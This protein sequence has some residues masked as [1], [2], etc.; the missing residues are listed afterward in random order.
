MGEKKICVYA[1]CKN[2]EKFVERWMNSMREADAV[3]VLDTGSDDRSVDRLRALGAVV[4]I[5]KIVPWRFDAA[6][7]ASL[8]MVPEDC[9]ICV[10]TDLDEVFRPGWR[11]ALEQSWTP[12][13]VR[14]RYRYTWNFRPDGSE[15]IVF[16]ADKIHARR[17]FSWV[18]PVHEVLRSE[19]ETGTTVTAVGVQLDHRADRTK[20]RSQYLPLLELSVREDPTDD[21]NMHYLG[22]EYMF[23]GRYREAVDT[24]LRHLALP[25]AR[26]ADERCASMRYIAR[27]YEALE[28][29]EEAERWYFRAVAEAPH[30]R[31]PWVENAGFAYR[32]REWSLVTAMCERALRI[33]ERPDT[34]MTDSEAWGALPYDL[35][36]IGCY[37]T[38]D[39][40]RAIRWIDRAIELSPD[41]E[42]LKQNRK[43]ILAKVF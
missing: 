15:G 8:E 31:E 17:G 32:Q 34:Y 43:L 37:Y 10:C 6:R 27:C 12:G 25:T 13:T 14:A 11:R 41:D 4:R 19:G 21:R 35:G 1:I 5:R 7:N 36:A 20:S 42:R 22:R 16:Y 26:W 18:H 39:L 2:E 38:G 30:L 3:Y 28:K 24:L 29:N 9:D 40:D 23:H 33:T